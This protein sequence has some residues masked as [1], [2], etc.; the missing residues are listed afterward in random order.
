MGWLE[1]AS[2]VEALEGVE[3]DAG[4][5]AVM[6]A[7]ARDAAGE[8]L[9]G[10]GWTGAAASVATGGESGAPAHS[11]GTGRPINFYT[12]TFKSFASSEIEA[13]G[14]N[15]WPAIS[16]TGADCKL[17]CD[18]CKGRI[19]A[20]MIEARTPATLRRVV[21]EQIAGGARGML[22]T[23]GSNLRNEV[24]YD[25]FYPTL[26]AIRDAHPG[27]RIAVHTG[28]VDSGMA[29]RMEDAGID[30]AMLDIIGA[31]ETITRVYHLKRPVADFETALAALNATSMRVVPH[32]VVGLHYGR[33]LGEPAALD[34][35]RRHPPSALVLVV[36]MPY[37]APAKKP[38]AI[39]DPVEVGRFFVE[40]RAALPSVPVLLGCARPPGRVKS[41]IDAYAV[42]AGLDGIAH[43][44]EGTVE[45]AVRIGRE[46]RVTPSCCSI[47][48]GEEVMGAV[49]GGRAGIRLDVDGVLAHE[50]AHR[51]GGRPVG[52]PVVAAGG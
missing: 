30:V 52:I 3:L 44:A 33:M 42:M 43:P 6:A 4:L 27:F 17:A 23:G 5:V 41:A 2:R 11:R 48:I 26:R 8:P 49:D 31:Q 25:P 34:I 1:L 37:Y 18:H 13:C 24:E 21:E 46:A 39:P 38:F 35:V 9:R 29:R 47:A 16:I 7:A 12:P 15:A 10:E 45:L 36:V 22:L 50:R 19:L 40:A 32:I 20:P 51:P 14:K 28:L